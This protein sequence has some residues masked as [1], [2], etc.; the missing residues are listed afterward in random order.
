MMMR[1]PMVHLPRMGWEP[2]RVRMTRPEGLHSG[3][4]FISSPPASDGHADFGR[5]GKTAGLLFHEK[6]V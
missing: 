5:S 4:A 3:W 6:L 2:L 1:S